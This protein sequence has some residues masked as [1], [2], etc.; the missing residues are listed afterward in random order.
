MLNYNG[1][2]SSIFYSLPTDGYTL[3]SVTHAVHHCKPNI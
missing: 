3:P 2:F 1:L